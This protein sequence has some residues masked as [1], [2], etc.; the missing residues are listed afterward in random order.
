VDLIIKV[1]VA[2]SQGE[3]VYILDYDAGRAHGMNSETFT[4][5][6]LNSPGIYRY[7]LLLVRRLMFIDCIMY[8]TIF[9]QTLA[10][11][12][13]VLKVREGGG[14]DKLFYVPEAQFMVV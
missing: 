5:Y 2:N 3:S 11:V 6:D 10:V 12:E 7:S 8:I 4:C 14:V 1:H 13:Q 9:I